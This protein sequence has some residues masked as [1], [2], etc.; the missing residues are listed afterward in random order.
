MPSMTDSQ[1]KTFRADVRREV[2]AIADNIRSEI[3]ADV[4]SNVVG[5][6]RSVAASTVRKDLPQKIEEAIS[7]K[8]SIAVEGDP[9]LKQEMQQLRLQNE[10]LRSQIEE[11]RKTSSKAWDDINDRILKVESP[12]FIPGAKNFGGIPGP[13][14]WDTIISPMGENLTFYRG[15]WRRNSEMESFGY[16]ARSRLEARNSE[17]SVA[18]RDVKKFTERGFI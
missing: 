8:V 10:M 1:F 2:H 5:E 15:E 6:A 12:Y 14:D 11:L 13:S 7:R 17:Y 16:M 9:D 4:Y 18:Y 3:R